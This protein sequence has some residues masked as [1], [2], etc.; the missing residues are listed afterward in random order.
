[1]SVWIALKLT[2]RRA[3]RVRALQAAVLVGCLKGVQHYSTAERAPPR[4]GI[5]RSGAIYC[6]SRPPPDAALPRK[7][8]CSRSSDSLD[9]HFE[10]NFE[11]SQAHT[12]SANST[13]MR[14]P[15]AGFAAHAGAGEMHEAGFVVGA[16]RA[17][18][19]GN[20]ER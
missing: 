20:S 19:A 5:L 16:A 6:N 7:R 2:E 12:P 13:E 8:S 4:T 14:L 11:A 15:M 17:C 18:K 3:N 1:M 9:Q 10:R